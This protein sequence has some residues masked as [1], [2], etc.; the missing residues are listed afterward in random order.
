MNKVTFKQTGFGL[1]ILVN[2]RVVGDITNGREKWIYLINDEAK[3][4]PVARAKHRPLKSVMNIKQMMTAILERMDVDTAIDHLYKRQPYMG[5]IV[6]PMQ[7]AHTLKKT[8][9]FGLDLNA[10]FKG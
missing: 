4:V 10:K 6:A 3:R 8:G 1:D 7:L 2:D 9:V 5:Q